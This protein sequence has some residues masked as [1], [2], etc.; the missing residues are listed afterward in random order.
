MFSPN[1][2]LSLTNAE[3]VLAAGLQAI[4]S[5][6]TDFDLSAVNEIDSAAVAILL[7][8]TRAAK[9]KNVTLIWHNSPPSLHSLAELYGVHALLHLKPETSKHANEAEQ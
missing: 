8:W 1:V 4:D 5:G 6:E 3:S 7:A 9:Q 2:D